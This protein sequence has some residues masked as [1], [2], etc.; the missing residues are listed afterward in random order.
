MSTAFVVIVPDEGVSYAVLQAPEG[1]EVSRAPQVP[2]V[3]R[4]CQEV[5]ADLNAQ[6]AAQYAVALLAQQA[7]EKT[8][9]DIV[10]EALAA[11]DEGAED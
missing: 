4:A 7:K 2:D 8:N 11:R 1:L 6:A 5:A 3:R 9:A 10:R